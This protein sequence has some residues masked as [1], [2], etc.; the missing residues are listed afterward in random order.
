[1]LFDD[2]KYDQPEALMFHWDPLFWE[3]GPEK[4]TY[5]R[6][7]LQEAVLAEMKRHNWKSITAMRYDIRDGTVG[8]DKVLKNHTAAWEEE[9][10][11]LQHDEFVINWYMN[12]DSV[13]SLFPEQYFGFFTKAPDRRV[14]VNDEEVAKLIRELA[15][16]EGAD[17]QGWSTKERAQ[18]PAKELQGASG[19]PFAQPVYGYVAQWV[20]EIADPAL[21]DGLLRHVD[22]FLSPSC[23]KD[24]FFYSFNDSQSD[25]HGNWK[26]V[27][28]TQG[29][30]ASG[31]PYPQLDS[32]FLENHTICNSTARVC[33]GD[34]N[35]AN[36]PPLNSSEYVCH[37]VYP[38]DLT[39]LNARY[40]DYDVDHLHQTK[41]FFMLRRQLKDSG[42]IATRVQ[43]QGLPNSTSN[44]TCR[45]EFVLPRLELQ[46]ISGPNPSFNIY[47]VSR[48]A[49]AIATW[50]EYEGERDALLF[51]TVN[52]QSQALERTRNVG[53][54]AAVNATA[55]NE[56]L[57]FRMA[58]MYDSLST[59][60]YW[61]F[62]NVEPPAFPVQGF[63]IVYGC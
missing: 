61:E 6:S 35:A 15:K 32:T 58:M 49:G 36:P 25:E 56:T 4:F 39:V 42:E 16:S 62:S 1:M 2:D 37:E 54:V 63:R 27:D 29:M 31:V 30:H 10:G 11:F 8:V 12:L 9:D 45:L 60:N 33:E 44:Y 46:K 20:S 24:G 48:E 22:T 28:L 5:S 57:S 13:Y 7:S 51:G 26:L 23:E 38:T 3:F 34:L 14:N 53:G 47:Q 41:Q 50:N 18:D 19:M 55:C 59:P 52:G 17:P 43:F 40:P 21:N